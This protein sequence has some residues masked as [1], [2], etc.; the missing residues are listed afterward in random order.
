M[1]LQQAGTLIK[2]SDMANEYGIPTTGPISLGNFYAGGSYGVLAA[3]APNVPTTKTNVSM[4][5][6]YGAFK[7]L[8]PAFNAASTVTGNSSTAAVTFDP[9]PYQTADTRYLGG[10]LWSLSGAPAG[11][12]INPSTGLLTVSQNTAVSG[13]VT[14]VATSP[15][16]PT[17]L[18]V[19]L[20]ITSYSRPVVTGQQ[21]GNVQLTST[22]TAY[23]FSQTATNTGAITWSQPSGGPPGTA[24]ASSTDS[25]C[26]LSLPATAGAYTI[27]ITATNPSGTTSAAA[28]I[29]INISTAAMPTPGPGK[30]V[31][32]F[33]MD[34]GLG[35]WI[36][37]SWLACPMSW[38]V[39]GAQAPTLS[40][41]NTKLAINVAGTGVG[42]P[43]FYAQLYGGGNSSTGPSMYA[44][45]TISCVLLSQPSSF[46]FNTANDGLTMA[47]YYYQPSSV[48]FVH[49]RLCSVNILGGFL[50]NNPYS[51]MINKVTGGSTISVGSPGGGY[52]CPPFIQNNQTPY[53]AWQIVIFT[54]TYST[55]KCGFYLNG[56]GYSPA[57]Y[58]QATL[59]YLT[60]PANPTAKT[61]GVL[62]ATMTVGNYADNI[63]PTVVN[64]Y[65]VYPST[66]ECFQG[67]IAAASV[68][69]YAVNDAEAAQIYNYYK[70][71]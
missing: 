29:S 61:L 54:T 56:G 40:T 65:T 6:F 59:A 43:A 67:K 30:T 25:A 21:L 28:T 45:A 41:D 27:S 44:T 35:G 26:Y 69:D 22:S 42:D 17:S 37:Q 18:A 14:V 10:L 53:D 66:A 46:G 34:L 51:L 36:R 70:S 19:P 20:S 58:D 64:G 62:A 24:I 12:T 71:L 57:S 3:G 15:A 2:V 11:V 38:N 8:K 13:T 47:V 68:F 60:F 63:N 49:P 7:V 31:L 50:S 1:V 5:K 48:T 39:S 9:T 4:T 23:F 16:G 52:M 32:P 55:G 33:A